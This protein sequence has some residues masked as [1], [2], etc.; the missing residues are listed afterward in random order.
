M[1]ECILEYVSAF[2]FPGTFSIL[3]EK[4]ISQG[5]KM[6]GSRNE[7]IQMFVET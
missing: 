4:E 2:F 5:K 3:L 7:F 1:V 6:G